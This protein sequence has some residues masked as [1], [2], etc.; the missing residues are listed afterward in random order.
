MYGRYWWLLCQSSTEERVSA[1][2]LQVVC[3]IP[4]LS[5]EV[6]YSR[7]HNITTAVQMY[8][9]CVVWYLILGFCDIPCTCAQDALVRGRSSRVTWGGPLVDEYSDSSSPLNRNGHHHGKPFT[10]CTQAGG[11]KASCALPK[12]CISTCFPLIYHRQKWFTLTNSTT[13]SSS[14]SV[15]QQP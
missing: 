7:V 13:L 4:W 3:M 6:T 11:T 15:I 10:T 2:V 1:G 14:P 12:F 5:C 9:Q 8:T